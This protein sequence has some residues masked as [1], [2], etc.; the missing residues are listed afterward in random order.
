MWGNVLLF[1][2]VENSRSS[3][4]KHR[5]WLTVEGQEMPISSL[6]NLSL[7]TPICPEVLPWE[8][9]YLWSGGGDS[10]LDFKE[11]TNGEGE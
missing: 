11:A 2:K 5:I 1:K 8:P 10:W 6:Y 4:A 9:G 7:E 3:T